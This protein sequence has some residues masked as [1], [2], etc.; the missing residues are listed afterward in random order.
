[1]SSSPATRSQASLSPSASQSRPISHD[2]PLETLVSHLLASKRSL[3]SISTV[4]RANEIVTTARSFLEESVKLS[5][6]TGF[7]RNCITDQAKLLGQVRRGVENVSKDGHSEF[8]AVIES[9][10]RANKRLES[11]M[12]VL[13]STMV[14]A[15][16]RP[17]AEEPRSLLDFIDEHS[18][19]TI[20]DAIKA[21]IRESREAQSSFSTS[22]LSFDDDLRELKAAITSAPRLN[23]SQSNASLTE[24]PIP[25][26][27]H[28]LETHAQEMASLLDS[29]VNHY[30]ACVDAVRHTEGGY[31]AVRD[32]TSNQPPDAEHVSMSGVM[33]TSQ[34]GEEQPLSE[35]ERKEMLIVLENDAGQVD[36]VVAELRERLDEMELRY[37]AIQEHVSKLKEAYDATVSAYKI[38]G[39]ISVHLPGYLMAA[40]DFRMHW[41]ETKEQIQEQLDE[42][43][44]MRLFYEQYYNSYDGLLLEA[45]RRNHSEQKIKNLIKKTMEQID[46]IREADMQERESFRAE[47]SDY[48]PGDLW[49]GVGDAA[50]KW[51]I[52]QLSSENKQSVESPNLERSVVEA[53]KRREKERMNYKR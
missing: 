12:D 33:S 17:V 21:S 8:E 14:Q 35:E 32:A 30:D 40:S 34:T 43:E 46:K 42:L 18:V 38:L 47:V 28:A 22:I 9:L 16:F 23:A 53:A 4:W 25:E 51:A 48:L 37:E 26:N 15:A 19:D 7:V 31:A 36:D 29:L 2:I 27:L 49:G 45:Y 13:R 52:Q 6:K 10:D 44:N 41:D 39:S 5:A 50:P 20:R 11:T 1:M 3:S 24:S